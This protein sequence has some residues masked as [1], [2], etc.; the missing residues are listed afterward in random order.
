M[1][2]VNSTFRRT[3]VAAVSWTPQPISR[4][5]GR[6]QRVNSALLF[7]AGGGGGGR[8]GGGEG[9]IWKSSLVMQ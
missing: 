5:T 4:T 7:L 6:V 2:I 9:N 1:I 3:I 8:G